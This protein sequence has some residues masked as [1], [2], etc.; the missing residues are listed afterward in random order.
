MRITWH[1]HS[2]FEINDSIDLVLDP[3]DGYSLGLRKPDTKADLV[4]ISHDHF[5]HNN[6]GVVSTKNTHV[7]QVPGKN[8]FRGIR[9][10]GFSVF[11]DKKQGAVRGKNIMFR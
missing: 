2:C 10:E 6:A 3:H 4:I 11:H 1:G 8:T 5:D 9:V 7:I